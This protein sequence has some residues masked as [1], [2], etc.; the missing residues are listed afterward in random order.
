MTPGRRNRSRQRGAALLL[1]LWLIALMTALVGGFALAARVENLQGQVMS[2]GVVA[3]NAARAG[4]EYALIRVEDQDQRRQWRPDGS[5][6][7]W[8]YAGAEIEVRL[9]DENGK[10]DLNQADASLLTALLVR[11]GEGQVGQEQAARFAAA[12]VDWRDPDQLTQPAGGAED[13]DYEGAERP[14][15]AKDSEFESVAELEQVLG[16]TPELFAK[17]EPF[18]TVYSGRMRPD[19]AFASAEVLDALGLNGKDVVAQRQRWNPEAGLP[20]PGLPGGESLM[21]ERSGTYS[22]DSRA[23]LADGRESLLRA[24]VRLGSAS[25]PGKIYTPLR[26]EEGAPPR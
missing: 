14:Y 10:V 23:K 8:S 6:N 12:I 24:V 16:F 5:P 4:L 15:G 20:P 7:R 9:I 2:R 1:V 26:W 13:Q 18:V 3:S 21:G 11:V 17:V 25:T 22:I 19:P